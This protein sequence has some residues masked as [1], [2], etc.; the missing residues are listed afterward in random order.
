MDDQAVLDAVSRQFPRWEP[1]RSDAGRL[2][3][4]RTGPAPAVPAGGAMT[5]SGD[6]ADE[7]RAELA[8]QEV[9]AARAG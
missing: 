1:W 9:I 2:W 8:A 4:T 6:D 3:A 5:V 7:L